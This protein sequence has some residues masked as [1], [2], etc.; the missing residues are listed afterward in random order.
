MA[1]YRSIHTTFWTDTKIVDDFT[2][3]DKYFML[4]CLTNSYTNLCGCYEISVKQMTRDLGY[5]E[6]TVLNLLKRFAE[7]HKVI[8]YDKETKELFI[9]NWSKY[10]WTNSSKLDKPLLEEIKNIKNPDFKRILSD[11]YNNR[12]TVSI[13]YLYGMDTTDTDTVSNTISNI[14]YIDDIYNNNIEQ[15]KPKRKSTRFVPPTL[16]EIQN[17]INEKNLNVDAKKFYDYF[18]VGEWVD[19][20]GNKVK[21]WKQ[22]LLT[23]NSSNQNK[24]RQQSNGMDDFRE[25]WEEMKAND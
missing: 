8:F 14:V 23:W 18:T 3:E 13:P 22:K 19:S 5:N 9:K 15:E 17:Y 1:I 11:E 6:E 10:N 25:M 20:K 2:P 12:D 4:Y 24:T 7:I 16:E 21:N